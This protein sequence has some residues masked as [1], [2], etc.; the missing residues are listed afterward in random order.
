MVRSVMCAYFSNTS[1]TAPLTQ[2]KLKLPGGQINFEVE[3]FRR[4]FAAAAPAAV[5]AWV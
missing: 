1:H 4:E 3:S 5:C 2:M